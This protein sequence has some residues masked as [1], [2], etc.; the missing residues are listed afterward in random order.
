MNQLNNNEQNQNQDNNRVFRINLRH[1]NQNNSNNV[2]IEDND[3]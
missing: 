1:I 3:G 2:E